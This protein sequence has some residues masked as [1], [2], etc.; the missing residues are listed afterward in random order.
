MKVCGAQIS[1]NL[2]LTLREKPYLSRGLVLGFWGIAEISLTLTINTEGNHKIQDKQLSLLPRWGEIPLFLNVGNF[3]WGRSFKTS[4]PFCK[5]ECRLVGNACSAESMFLKAGDMGPNMSGY[6]TGLFLHWEVSKVVLNHFVIRQ[7][8]STHWWSYCLCQQ[9]QNY[10]Q[11]SP[12]RINTLHY[13][14][15]F[16]CLHHVSMNLILSFPFSDEHNEAQ[17]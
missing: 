11:P 8:E 1:Y 3:S 14:S 16:L 9:F 12:P 17:T 6:I 7:I 2:S 5:K 10:F 13:I 15:F 4:C